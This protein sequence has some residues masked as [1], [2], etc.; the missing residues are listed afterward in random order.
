MSMESFA[1]T[2]R[3]FSGGYL[4]QPVIDETKLPGTWD[5]T[6]KWTFKTDLE[7]QGADG[8]TLFAALERQPARTQ[9]H[10]RFSEP[11]SEPSSRLRR[12]RIPR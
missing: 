1:A 9:L 4:E 5:F 12:S 6:L 8:I 11:L 7:K 10:P 3:E 2:L